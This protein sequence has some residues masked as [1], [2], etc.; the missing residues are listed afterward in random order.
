MSNKITRRN[1]DIIDQLELAMSEDFPV[2]NCPVTHTFTDG[3]YIRQI[4]MP[5]G[6]L[7]TSKIHLTNHPYNVSMGHAK[8]C[9]DGSDWKD[10]VAPYNGVTLS[11]TRRILYIVED[12]IWTTYHK[13]DTVS[14]E[15]NNLSDEEKE[16]IVNKI[17]STII[18]SRENLLLNKKEVLCL[19]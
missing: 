13:I 8:V 2:V 6:T 7:I 14:V 11:G 9:I 5:K 10:I 16:E 4:F 18:D 12:C 1:D 3:I 17:E 15:D 19:G